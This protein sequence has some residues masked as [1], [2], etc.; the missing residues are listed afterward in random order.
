MSTGD[1]LDSVQ[2]ILE[3]AQTDLKALENSKSMEVLMDLSGI[4]GES[5]ADFM[6]SPVEVETKE[7]YSIENYGSALA[8]FYTNLAI[9]VGGIVLIA[10][11]KLEADK[12][13]VGKFS[14][15]QGYFGRWLLFVAFGV[16]QS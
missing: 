5:V 4:D 11:F 16:V 1:S 6:S 13:K 12:E 8:P 14:A 9:W 15:V 3:N 7:V 10:I 2:N